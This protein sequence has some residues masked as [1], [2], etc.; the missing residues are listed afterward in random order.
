MD[1]LI[2]HQE[3]GKERI[4]PQ[5]LQKLEASLKRLTATRSSLSVSLLGKQNILDTFA[6]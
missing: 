5:L 3:A 2:S 1:L 4:L 6:S